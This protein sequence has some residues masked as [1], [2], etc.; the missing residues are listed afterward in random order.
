MATKQARWVS[1]EDAKEGVEYLVEFN[2]GTWLPCVKDTNPL[3]DIWHNRQHGRWKGSGAMALK[4]KRYKELN[5]D[6]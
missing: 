2:D 1:W 5:N 4:F 3:S 6:K